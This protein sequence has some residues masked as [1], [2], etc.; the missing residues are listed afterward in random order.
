MNNQNQQAT[1]NEPVKTTHSNHSA[2]NISLESDQVEF[3]QLIPVEEAA[4][5]RMSMFGKNI[6]DLPQ[7]PALW[8]AFQRAVKEEVSSKKLGEIIQDDPVLSASI[9]RIANAPGLGV[10][11]ALYD[12]SRAISHLGLT[13]VRT[14]VSRHSF[15]ASIATSDK[16]YDIQKLWKHSMAVSAFAE[17]ISEHIPDCDKD[18]ATALGLFHDIGKMSLNLFTQFMQPAKLDSDEGHLKFE[19]ERFSCTHIDLGILL[20]KHWQL[21]EN[22]VRGIQYHHHP[23]FSAAETIPEDI[24]PE[25]FA[26]YLAD[27]LAIRLGFDTGDTGIVT[28][29]E[30]F[31]SLLPNTTL[32]E[33]MNLEKV[34]HEIKRIESIEF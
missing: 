9:L 21:P 26:V 17:I 12:V 34:Q 24:R 16:V 11:T 23:A 7:P 29:H 10:R 14:I 8:G 28:P 30:S 13:L 19:H 2:F 33:L 4:A 25:V 18:E 5:S 1:H 20:A 3:K 27:L 6:Q 32:T 15:S 31:A 22:I